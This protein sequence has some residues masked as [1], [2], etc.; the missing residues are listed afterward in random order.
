ML[1]E[2]HDLI[3]EFP[4]YHKIIHELKSSNEH[5]AKLFNEYEEI[6]HE[7]HLIEEG[8]EN[9]SDEYLEERK[10]RRVHLKDELYGMLREA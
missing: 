10:I 8:I 6:D 9:T 5:F 4:E 2:N 7:I 1:I 3:H